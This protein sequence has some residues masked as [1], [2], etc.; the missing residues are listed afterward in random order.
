MDSHNIRVV[1]A[2]DHPFIRMGLEVEL[3]RA[4]GIHVVGSSRDST[5]LVDMLSRRECDV[6][7]TDY[8]MPG[9]AHGDGLELL[10]HIRRNFVLK[11][12]VVL[13]GID[14]PALI[15]AL[16][17]SGITHI[18][19]KTDAAIHVIP[20]IKAAVLGRGYHSPAIAGML[21]AS[22]SNDPRRT[23]SRREIAVLKLFVAGA[24][25]TAIAKRLQRSKQTISAQKISAMNKLGFRNEAELFAYAVETGQFHRID[26]D[27]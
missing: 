27:I 13:T 5:E 19:S 17:T 16:H 2:D 23:L 25:I 7:L 12:I 18:V 4:S 24:S 10:D 6:V 22:Q 11:G 8:A 14:R 26:D 3:E 1:I 20:A 9:G 15:H 21:P